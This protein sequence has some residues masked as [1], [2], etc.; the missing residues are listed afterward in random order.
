MK[1]RFR[2]RES[3]YV[4]SLQKKMFF[5]AFL[6]AA[7]TEFIEIIAFTIDTIIVCTYFG[8][9][10]IAA[11]GL[12]GPVFFLIGMPAACF[13]GGLQTVCS[14]EMGRGHIDA[15]CRKF[16]R[17]M[18]FA[19]WT[20]TIAGAVLLLSV[21]KLAFLFGA[22]GNAADIA[23]LT[24]QYMYGVGLSAVPYVLLSAM[25][26]VAVLDNGNRTVVISAAVGAAVNIAVDIA[27]AVLGWGLFGIG[28]ATAVSYAVSAVIL[29]LHFRN[30]ENVIRFTRVSLRPMGIEEIIRRGLTSASYYAAGAIRSVVLNAMVVSLGGGIGM[31]VLALHGT[32]LDFVNII[33]IAIAGALGILAGITYGERNEEDMG[34]FGALAHRY[35]IFLSVLISAILF[36]FRRPIAGFFLDAS[37]EGFPLMLYAIVCIAVSCMMNALVYSRVS[38]LQAVGKDGEARWMDT[39]S[40]LVCYL[41]LALLLSF[42]MGVRGVFAAFPA[43]MAL[44]LASV[45]LI[46]GKRSGRRVPKAGDYLG[47]EGYSYD[48]VRDTIA[49]PVSTPEECMLLS[50]QIALF[51]K[52]HRFSPKTAYFASLAAE[53]ITMNA[54]AG[55]SGFGK[56]K[57]PLDIR[58]VIEDGTLILRMRD[59]GQAF[60]LSSL[61]R[62]IDEDGDPARNIGTRM[63]CSLADSIDHYRIYGMNTTIIRIRDRKNAAYEE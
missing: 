55:G 52:G 40:N 35:I 44:V 11:V 42:P 60:N 2:A 38:Y 15:V 24:S 29:L 30:K 50:E 43:S 33:P 37:S 58:V 21:P 57:P 16:S 10:E 14:H 32:I 27:S 17:T 12:A 4:S 62:M 39:A 51:C 19:A 53:E 31:S 20:M 22:R 54:L 8:E 49:Y 46:Y 48:P 9:R 59:N 63:I 47:M 13:A 36:L 18:L 5:S 41:A 7:Y 34:S 45:F 25:T 23:G 28:T 6:T 1:G 61:S 3:I 26:P 56:E